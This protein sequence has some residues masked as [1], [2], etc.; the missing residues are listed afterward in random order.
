MHGNTSPLVPVK[1]F[2]SDLVPWKP[3]G[4][5]FAL[6]RFTGTV[7]GEGRI[8]QHEARE[9]AVD[10]SAPRREVALAGVQGRAVL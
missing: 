10:P 5:T 9:M 7:G 6:G 1:I 3:L 8:S 2:L 4:Q